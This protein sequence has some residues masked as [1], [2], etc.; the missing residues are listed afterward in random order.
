MYKNTFIPCKI[1]INVMFCHSN[2]SLICNVSPFPAGIF[3]IF[4][5]KKQK[6]NELGEYMLKHAQTKKN[7]GRKLFLKVF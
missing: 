2:I 6:N 3:V 4:R 7:N 5:K 1:Y